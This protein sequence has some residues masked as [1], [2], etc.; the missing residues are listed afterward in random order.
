MK[1]LFLFVFAAGI[2]VSAFSGDISEK[3]QELIK[4]LRG[5]YRSMPETDP[6]RYAIELMS[7]QETKYWMNY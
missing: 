1:K 7:D 3:D 6:A 2:F 5:V 4:S